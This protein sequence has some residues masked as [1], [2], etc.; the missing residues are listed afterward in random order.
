MSKNSIRNFMG[1]LAIG[2]GLAPLTATASPIVLKSS[3][4]SFAEA[5]SGKAG[6]TD[7]TNIVDPPPV[8]GTGAGSYGSFVNPVTAVAGPVLPIDPTSVSLPGTTGTSR[9]QVINGLKVSSSGG[10]TKIVIAL[11]ALV[12]FQ[13]MDGGGYLAHASS[14][15]FVDF[16]LSGPTP[17]ILKG[18]SHWDAGDVLGQLGINAYLS[19]FPAGAPIPSLAT[20]HGAAL[21]S[22]FFYSGVIDP[23]D[24]FNADSFRFNGNVFM[25]GSP[26]NIG[27]YHGNSALVATLVLNPVP[28]P[29]PLALL[30]VGFAV[31]VF[32]K[33]RKGPAHLKR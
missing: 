24:F 23:A 31:L 17:F 16:S 14:A 7:G 20:P 6:S 13:N 25:G 4:D 12:D 32:R 30:G 9:G 22:P 26:I 8:G 10:Q 5:L 18:V 33:A 29:S 1:V 11:D 27:D 3:L 28:E 19:G 21:P 15:F 2:L